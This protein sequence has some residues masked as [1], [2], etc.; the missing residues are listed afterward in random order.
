[1]SENLSPGHVSECSDLWFIDQ[2]SPTPFNLSRFRLILLTVSRQTTAMLLDVF[3]S[4]P[5]EGGVSLWESD[6]VTLLRF[7]TEAAFSHRFLFN[8]YI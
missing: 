3:R 5:S 2:L 4:A 6:D 1:M 7:L 8:K